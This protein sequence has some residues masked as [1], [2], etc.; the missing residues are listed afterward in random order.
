M[1]S[2]KETSLQ[3]P[4]PL[5][6]SS[7]K[8]KLIANKYCASITPRTF[9]TKPKKRLKASQLNCNGDDII[10]LLTKTTSTLFGKRLWEMRNDWALYASVLH[11]K[12]WKVYLPL[13]FVNYLI[14][15][16]IWIGV[17]RAQYENFPHKFSIEGI[18]DGMD[19]DHDRSYKRVTNWKHQNPNST[20]PRSTNHDLR[21]H[22]KPNC[23][24][25]YRHWIFE[26][27][28]VCSTERLRILSGIPRN[29][30]WNW[31]GANT[32][33][34]LEAPDSSPGTNTMLW[35]LVLNGYWWLQ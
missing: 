20:K 17:S 9:N 19:T 23:K 28:L 35:L 18:Y 34:F 14:T 11:R 2:L 8:M 24:E 5:R 29:V 27:V 30:L 26:S 7:E 33:L 13:D 1:T 25:T 12:S 32:Y 10:W 4:E 31:Y 22:L 6:N 3:K 15:Q 16:P 21:H